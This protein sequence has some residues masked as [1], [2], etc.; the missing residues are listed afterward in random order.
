MSECL[1][2]VLEEVFFLVSC[3]LNTLT[4]WAA[5]VVKLLHVMELFAS[6]A[7]MDVK[8]K[9][10]SSFLQAMWVWPFA[11]FLVAFE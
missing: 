8:L 10:I 4:K 3:Q 1:H 11:V 5:D 6:A 9:N 7:E 2:V